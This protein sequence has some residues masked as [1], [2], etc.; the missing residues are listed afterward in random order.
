MQIKSN[1]ILGFICC[2]FFLMQ[3]LKLPKIENHNSRRV[4]EGCNRF[5]GVFKVL[6]VYHEKYLESLSAIYILDYFRGTFSA[7]VIILKN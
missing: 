5:C 6:S 7:M 1:F 2:H 3:Q 4:K